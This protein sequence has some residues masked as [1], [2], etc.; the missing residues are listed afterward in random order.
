ME[1]EGKEKDG[2]L[3]EAAKLD[4]AVHVLKKKKKK[5]FFSRIMFKSK[6]MDSLDKTEEKPGIDTYADFIKRCPLISSPTRTR[7]SD[8]KVAVCEK[9]EKDRE[10]VYQS[11][12]Y[13]RQSN[14]VDNYIV[15]MD[16]F[17]T[18]SLSKEIGTKT[19]N[20]EQEEDGFFT[21]F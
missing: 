2:I 4:A 21:Q 20:T 1:I 14:H 5:H 11:L 17:Y 3:W 13:Y 12:K 16:K 9:T 6:S 7:R 18:K 8:R 15:P 10:L 19:D